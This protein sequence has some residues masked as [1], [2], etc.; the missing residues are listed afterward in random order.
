MIYNT[1][2]ATTTD[3]YNPLNNFDNF[4][5]SLEHRDTSYNSFLVPK[6]NKKI[7]GKKPNKRKCSY[8]SRFL[9]TK[10]RKLYFKTIVQNYRVFE[11]IEPSFFSYVKVNM[12]RIETR[13]KTRR[14]FNLNKELVEY[15]PMTNRGF[16]YTIVF[17]THGIKNT[18]V[19]MSRSKIKFNKLLTKFDMN[20]SV[21]SAV[22]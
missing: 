12:P 5:L 6:A 16:T 15:I 1:T 2:S 21:K 14:F 10:K 4:N 3:F 19:T 7:K 13:E 18:F 9:Q 22:A 8:N 20:V 11:D 17:V